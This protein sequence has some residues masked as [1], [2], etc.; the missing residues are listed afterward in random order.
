VNIDDWCEF[1]GAVVWK[2]SFFPTVVAF[3]LLLQVW[4]FSLVLSV[5]LDRDRV[6]QSLILACGH[7]GILGY[8]ISI[9]LAV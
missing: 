9:L 3:R 2:I 7:W 4:I 1:V 5:E 6:V 8:V